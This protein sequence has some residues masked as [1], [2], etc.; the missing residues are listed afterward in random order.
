MT[1]VHYCAV[2]VYVVYATNV[3]LRRHIIMEATKGLQIKM[4]DTLHKRFKLYTVEN[5]TTM[6]DVI[7]GLVKNFI[8]LHDITEKEKSESKEFDTLG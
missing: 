2:L 7:N 1:Q 3:Y 6:S 4:P 5:D 8:T